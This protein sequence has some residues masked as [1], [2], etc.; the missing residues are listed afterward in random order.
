VI[1]FGQDERARDLQA[2]AILAEAQ[3]GDAV[4]LWHLLP[5]RFS[6]SKTI[7]YKRLAA[8]VPPPPEATQDGI[9]TL[10]SKCFAHGAKHSTTLVD[11]GE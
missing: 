10:N 1:D 4:T 11:E 5:R 7:I 6:R 9:L 3:D 8:I 2:G